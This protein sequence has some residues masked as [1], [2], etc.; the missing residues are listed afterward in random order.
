MSSAM[1][2]VALT[3]R[4]LCGVPYLIQPISLAFSLAA[5]QAS[6]RKCGKLTLH[7]SSCF[8]LAENVLAMRRLSSAF[9]GDAEVGSRHRYDNLVARDLDTNF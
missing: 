3:P 8:F 2:T 6:K 1:S 4:S 9:I 7:I 5:V